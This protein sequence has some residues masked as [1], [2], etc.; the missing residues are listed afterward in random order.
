M[1][2]RLVFATLLI[3]AAGLTTLAR[4]AGVPSPELTRA[5]GAAATTPATP[6]P[7][8]VAAAASAAPARTAR[9]PDD[10]WETIIASVRPA[11]DDVL[12]VLIH[13]AVDCPYCRIWKTASDGL[14]SAK[15]IV[16]ARPKVRM[17]LVERQSLD[18]VEQRSQYPEELLFEFERRKAGNKLAPGV[19]SFDVFLRGKL[20]YSTSGVVR[21]TTEVIPVLLTLEG[22]RDEARAPA[23]L[24]AD[25]GTVVR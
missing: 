5:D 10:A 22:R 13:S 4:A 1:H 17:F 16:D 6:P 9:A 12:Y 2:A 14:A 8:G 20:V 23:L 25:P 7:E 11:P 21:W 18:G 24:P 3:A 15:K 19:P